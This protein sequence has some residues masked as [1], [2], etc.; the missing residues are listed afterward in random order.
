MQ[1][2]PMHLILETALLIIMKKINWKTLN[3]F[4]QQ[5]L[6]SIPLIWLVK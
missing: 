3:M 6:I 1:I 2:P 4:F 5:E